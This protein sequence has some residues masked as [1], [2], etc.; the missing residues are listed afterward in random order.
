MCRPCA[1]LRLGR[2]GALRENSTTT[3]EDS[4]SCEKEANPKA[5]YEEFS[6]RAEARY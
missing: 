3:G 2:L 1:P 5:L 6:S 4:L